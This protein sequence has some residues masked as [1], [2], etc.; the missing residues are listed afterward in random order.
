MYKKCTACKN[1]YP[2]R[3]GHTHTYGCDDKHCRAPGYPGYVPKNEENIVLATVS[4]EDALL[5]ASILRTY[6]KARLNCDKNAVNATACPI[7]DCCHSRTP[8]DWDV[9]LL[10]KKPIA[11]EDDGGGPTRGK[12]LGGTTI[13]LSRNILMSYGRIRRIWWR[14]RL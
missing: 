12:A 3:A 2:E 10:M 8:E 13:G 11:C 9:P 4:D 6:C 14:L 5:A 7:C 1:R